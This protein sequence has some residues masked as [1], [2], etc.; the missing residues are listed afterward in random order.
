MRSWIKLA[1][2]PVGLAA[3]AFVLV[4][5]RSDAATSVA[6]VTGVYGGKMGFKFMPLTPL[7]SG[8]HGSEVTTMQVTQSGTNIAINLTL[9]TALGPKFYNIGGSYGENLFFAVGNSPDGHMVMTGKAS[10]KAPKITLKGDAKLVSASGITILKFTI[11]E[12]PPL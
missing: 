1:A 7:D 4:A 11:H 5:A 6:D 9:D 8:D 10:G 3:A 12:T 2:L